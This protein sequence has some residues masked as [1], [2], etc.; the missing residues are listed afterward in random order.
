MLLN[1]LRLGSLKVLSQGLMLRLSE[2]LAA[3]YLAQY[4]LKKELCI[5]NNIAFD[6]M[7]ALT[8]I[9]HMKMEGQR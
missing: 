9:G 1:T 6:K 4:L 3:F 2:W 7:E 5:I 8:K